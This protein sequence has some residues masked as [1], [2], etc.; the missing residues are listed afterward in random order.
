MKI[1]TL[2]TAV[3]VV[4]LV[5]PTT[6]ITAL[7][8][9]QSAL[10]LPRTVNTIPLPNPA[11]APYE[12]L[13]LP[14]PDGQTLHGILFPANA[15]SSTLILAF[16]GNA[17]D[18]IGM[19]S[20]LKNTVFPTQPIS[21]AAFSYR[22]YPN[23]FGT[24]STGTPTEA[25]LYADAETIYDTL[26]SRLHP[27]RTYAVGYSLGTAVSTHLATVRPLAGI[28]LIAPP[29]SI[30]RLAQERYPYVPV[31]ALLKYP[32]A[33]EDLLGRVTT[34]VTLIYT[35]TDGLIPPHHI[36]I[37]KSAQPAARIV[38]LQGSTHGTILDNPQLPAYL[39]EV[40]E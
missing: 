4:I 1:R 20:F 34:P 11:A 23:V 13:A 31:R 17:Q 30:R 29:A 32:F 28:A 9:R 33:T 6:F 37:L 36:E 8:L 35:P 7:Y 14:T 18:V 15:P 12:K 19:A 26:T 3:A 25:S 27:A 5:V 24:P 21:V 39:R 10:I 40:L 2:L 22:G 16:G 38:R